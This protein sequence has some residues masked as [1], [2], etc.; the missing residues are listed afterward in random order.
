MNVLKIVKRM[1]VQMSKASL[2]I[3]SDVKKQ[4]KEFKA[5]SEKQVGKISDC[6]FLK[7]LIESNANYLKYLQE[8]RLKRWEA[9]WKEINK[10]NAVIGLE[11]FKNQKILKELKGE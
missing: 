5:Y 2:G 1:G 6:N 11:Q 3:N 10:E 9:E 7:Y 4:F 8:V